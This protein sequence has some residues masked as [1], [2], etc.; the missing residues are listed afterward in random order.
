MVEINDANTGEPDEA[1]AHAVAIVTESAS[2]HKVGVMITRI[3]TGSYI[4][5]AHPAVPYGLVRQQH[6]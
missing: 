6:S 1:L 4:V 2:F 3:G 5:R